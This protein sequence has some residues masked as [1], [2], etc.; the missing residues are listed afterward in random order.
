MELPAE[1]AISLNPTG[2][3]QL[4]PSK[5]TLASLG[6]QHGTQVYVSYQR[7]LT[8]SVPAAS[9]NAAAGNAPSSLPTQLVPSAI[10]QSEPI[11]ELIEKQD[12][13]IKRKRDA[14][15]YVFE[16]AIRLLI[17]QLQTR[18]LGNV[19]L[20]STTRAVRSTLL[21][22]KQNQAHAFPRIPQKTDK[23]YNPQC[24]I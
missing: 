16:K 22:T 4:K 1:F 3:Q 17:M 24:F 8:P 10:G 5:A 11:D 9:E 13:L 7:D 2:K 6:L 14:R 21:G 15:L 12:G 23:L 18:R 20:L 19:R